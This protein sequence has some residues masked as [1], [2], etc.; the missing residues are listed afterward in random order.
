MKLGIFMDGQSGFTQSR[1]VREVRKE[2]QGYLLR[3]FLRLSVL[4]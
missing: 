2:E 1:K 3:A 4:A